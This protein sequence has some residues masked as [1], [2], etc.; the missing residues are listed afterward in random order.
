MCVFYLFVFGRWEIRIRTHTLAFT[1]TFTHAIVV[2]WQLKR[3]L[4]TSL[5]LSFV[6]FVFFSL[7]HVL[8]RRRANWEDC[9]EGGEEEVRE[10]SIVGFSLFFSSSKF[11]R[12]LDTY[13]HWAS[14]YPKPVQ[15]LR[16]HYYLVF[17]NNLTSLLP[18]GFICASSPSF[19][20]YWNFCWNKNG[21]FKKGG[22]IKRRWGIYFVFALVCA[23]L[24][25]TCVTV[26]VKVSCAE[27]APPPLPP[28]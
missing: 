7:V 9:V 4:V 15:P 19:I 10:V 8:W 24:F 6:L 3:A 22:A 21:E 13:T 2:P 27:K 14:C 17:L 18:L 5:L 28:Q 1:H 12:Y 20:K 11:L 23:W 16:Q 25:R 26:E